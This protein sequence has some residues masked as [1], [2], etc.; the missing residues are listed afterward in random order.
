MNLLKKLFLATG[1]FLLFLFTCLLV[2]QQAGEWIELNRQKN[3]HPITGSIYTY[4]IQRGLFGD[5]HVYA[6][7][8]TEN[9][10]TE[11]LSE[12]SKKQF[13]AYPDQREIDGY[14][15]DGS[16]HT[17]LDVRTSVTVHVVVLLSSS[18]IHSSI[19]F[20]SCRNCVRSRN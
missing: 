20:I 3:E 9:G 2:F 19:F 12:L 13:E 14:W 6:E 10:L 16:F 17:D 7:V 15:I 1:G 5:M 11:E 18:Y 4:E 8:L